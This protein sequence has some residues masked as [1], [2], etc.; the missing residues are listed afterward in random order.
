[1]IEQKEEIIVNVINK[2]KILTY[3][4]GF[5]TKSLDDVMLNGIKRGDIIWLKHQYKDRF[6][7]DPFLLK[8]DEKY[9]YIL[10]EEYIFWEEKGK[11]TILKVQKSNFVLVEKKVVIEEAYHLSFPACVYGGNV[12]K[13]EACKS[14]KYYEYVIDTN[15]FEIVS[16]KEILN[17]PAID[18][19]EYEKDGEFWLFTGK[20]KRPSTELYVYKK[21]KDGKYISISENPLVVDNSCARSAG[22]LFMWREKLYRPVQDCRE[23]YGRQT[24]IMEVLKLD[25][26]GYMDSLYKTINSFDNPPFSDTMHTFNVYEDCIIVDGSKDF[27]RFPMK[28]FY[29][30]MRFI[31]RILSK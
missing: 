2:F 21:M 23:R 20:T 8:Q 9:F 5:I 12:I 1:M 22:A 15:S 30:K 13:P 4:I 10:C 24:Q 27:L 25:N 6:F 28:F 7:A 16:K 29:K 31:F 19:I 26:E 14:G 11:I 18:A 17:E 3:N